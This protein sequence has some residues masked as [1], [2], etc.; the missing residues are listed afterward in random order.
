MRRF[1]KIV[2]CFSLIGGVAA[3]AA[4]PDWETLGKRWWAHVQ[5]LA[6][7]KLEGRNTGSEGYEKAAAYVTEQF[8]NAGLQPAGATGYVQPVEFNVAE[9]DE[10]HSSLELIR[11]GKM[12]AVKFG[13]EAFITAGQ[14]LA[15]SAEAD[16]VFVGYGFSVPELKYDDFAGLSIRRREKEGAG[17]SGS[18]R[19]GH[20]TESQDGR[21]A[22][23]A[24]GGVE[25]HAQNVF[26]GTR[27][28]RR[29]EVEGGA[30]DPSRSGG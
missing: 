22:V 1:G 19:N 11:E 6:D 15:D 13:D 10:E 30:G 20:D 29:S 28:R 17:K 23:V 27:G 26:A 18:D 2:L 4:G 25:V 9:L 21:S 14:D 5:Y 8:K 16:A 12:E 24:N 7:D 3:I